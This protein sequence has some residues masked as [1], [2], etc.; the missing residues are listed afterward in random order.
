MQ[1]YK[2]AYEP[3]AFASELPSASLAEEEKRKV[4]ISTGALQSI[5]YL[6]ESLNV[7]K[8]PLLA[9]QFFSRSILR[10]LFCPPL[11]ILLLITNILI[12]ARDP[13]AEIYNLV[14]FAQAVFYLLALC[15]WILVRSGKR[16]G[17]FTIP[18]YFIFMNYC[19]A[20]GFVKFMKGQQSVLW[21]KSLRQAVE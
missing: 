1:G 7:F 9:F 18:F 14:L 3:G 11:L 13:Q 12:V 19:Q 15:G 5:G 16:S 17:V 8:Y 20:K 10:W 21:E 2:I 6:K 4:R